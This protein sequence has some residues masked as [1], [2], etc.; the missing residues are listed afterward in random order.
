[1]KIIQI[2]KKWYKGEQIP[3]INPPGERVVFI[4]AYDL[5]RHWTAKCIEP[6]VEFYLNNW[7]KILTA[8]IIATITYFIFKR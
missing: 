4:N 7:E 6:F 3:Y 2:I 5:K 1:M 8:L